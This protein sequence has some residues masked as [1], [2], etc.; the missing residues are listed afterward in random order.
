MRYK[1][2][3]TS[4]NMNMLEIILSK[5]KILVNDTNR[6][7]CS[8]NQFEPEKARLARRIYD[9][10]LSNWLG[11]ENWHTHKWKHMYVPSTYYMCGET[12]EWIERQTN[13][14]YVAI[15]NKGILENKFK[16]WTS[17]AHWN[18]EKNKE[19]I[20]MCELVKDGPSSNTPKVEDLQKCTKTLHMRSILP[21]QKNCELK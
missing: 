4:T 14:F 15:I 1:N 10:N 6:N 11:C 17:R 12:N 19:K 8:D 9:K 18:N 13:K 5:L 21:S 7:L 3:K 16:V 2:I 20:L